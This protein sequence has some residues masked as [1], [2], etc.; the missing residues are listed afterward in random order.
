M[1]ISGYVKDSTTGETLIG[2]SLRTK[3]GNSGTVTNA[4]GFFTLNLPSSVTEIIC[5]YVGYQPKII[6]IATNKKQQYQISLAPR[7]KQEREVVITGERNNRNVQSTEMSRIELS[8]EKIKSLPV[9]FGEPDVLKAITLLPG[10]KSGGE[11]STGFYVRGGGPDQNLILMDE[12]VVYNPSHL[13]GFLSVF[14]S[15]AVKNIDIIKG[16]MPA[17]YGGRLSSILNVNMREGNNQ[18]FKYSGGIGLISSRISAEGPIKKGKSSFLVA[19]RRTYIDVLARPFLPNQIKGNSYYF[20]DLNLKMNFI[21]SDK[22]RLF[23]SGYFGRDILDY[24]S[25]IN[26]A[27]NFNFGWGN[28]T[29]TLRWNHVFNPKLFVNT[30]VIFNRYELFNDFQF[31]SG[32]FNVRSNLLDWNLKSDFTWSPIDKHQVK[33][34]FNY[35]YHT[36]QPGILSGNI[37]STDI[38]QTIKKQFAH[39]YA[40]YVLDEW[41]VNHRLTLNYGLR[42]V[43]FQLVGPYT[44]NE[45]DPDTQLPTSNSI[46]Y[47]KGETIAFYPRIEPRI[48]STY[49]LSENSSIKA[50]YTQTY[51]FL[52]L[53]TTSGAQFPIDL[54]VPSSKLVQ[55]QMARQ[56]A[57]G[58]YRNFKDN[59]YETSAEIYYKPMRNQ[60]EFKPGA[61]LFFN[62]NLENEMVF[63]QGLSYGLELFLRKKIGN[64]NG[65]IGYT[66]SKTTRQF[67]AL[68]DGKP[69]FYRYDR[70]HDISVLLSYQ[71]NKKWSGNFVFVYGTGNATTLPDSRYAYRFGV[72]P[73][74][75]EPK[76]IF[77]DKY[78]KVNSFRMPAYHRADISFTYL[79]K[80]TKKFE[81]SW[82]FSIYNVYNRANPYFIYF[83]PDIK[84]QTVKAYMVY[85][86]PIVP[87]VQWNFK[88]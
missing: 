21:L 24:Q 66:W 53:A 8:G 47:G 1:S 43:A 76:F 26:D 36:F 86:F 88:F 6:S 42:L 85:L 61:N 48:N 56:Y 70:T 25:Q 34:G 7:N 32:G 62:Q 78:S 63:G 3:D 74:T 75:G 60:I 71:F 37:G 52:H 79:H 59:M 19:A 83:Y 18:N 12:A 77:I 17:N 15:D 68:N 50:S 73:T 55:P 5:S 54:W 9:I 58:Y 30:A 44:Q 33:F 82:N 14:N 27:V 4:Y 46:S 40:T 84:T 28:S 67:D 45:Y 51:Q 29:A 69:Y 41:K 64:F 49:L 35:T 11:A 20:Y 65:W 16:G 23:I 22:D 39:E 87:S 57:L 80:Q 31:G 2:A 10:I 72:D 81:S 38:S 13:F